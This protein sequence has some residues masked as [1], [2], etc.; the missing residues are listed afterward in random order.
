VKQELNRKKKPPPDHGG[1]KPP[2]KKPFGINLSPIFTFI[3]VI[4]GPLILFNLFIRRIEINV[5]DPARNTLDAL[6][7]YGGKE[8][9]A[10]PE[11]RRVLWMPRL[12]E[13][14]ITVKAKGHILRN[15]TVDLYDASPFPVRLEEEGEKP[16]SLKDFYPWGDKNLEIKP[17]V[18]NAIRLNGD[19]S[20][21]A[22][23]KIE[24]MAPA[25][26]TLILDIDNINESDFRENKLLKIQANQNGII[27]QPEGIE[28]VNRE[29]IPPRTGRVRYRMP[30]DFDGKLEFVFYHARLDDLIITA[31]YRN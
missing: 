23:Y 11:G 15:L 19:L 18:E 27:L 31:W 14:G 25:G 3:S 4:G 9:D 28:L 7:I 24:D 5:Y 6:V 30:D 12:I 1:N 22:G 10:D 17:V 8:R 2:E 29:Y 13:Q 21:T 16:F 26:K 20:G